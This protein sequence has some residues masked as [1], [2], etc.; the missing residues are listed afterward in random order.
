MRGSD[1]LARRDLLKLWLGAAIPAAVVQEPGQR[2]SA[3]GLLPSPGM[4]GQPRRPITDYENDPFVVGIEEQLRCTCGCN[5]D[6]YTCRTTDFTCQTSPALHRQVVSLVEQEKT[7]QEVIDEFVAQYGELVLMSPRKEGFNLVGYAL[8]GMAIAT[9]GAAM[10]W[11]LARRT[12][13]SRVTAPVAEGDGLLR[14]MSE[15]DTARLQ[16]ELADLDR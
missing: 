11:I 10:L 8:P 1:A 2:D 9:V 12:G 5:L 3:V 6:V 14:E 4:A 16:S 13:G 7:A 15:E